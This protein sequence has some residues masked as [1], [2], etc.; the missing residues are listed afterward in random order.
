[1]TSTPDLSIVVCS[2]NRADRLGPTLRA[3]E[4]Q[5]IRDR[6]E[7]VIVDDCSNPPIDESEVSRSGAK[8]LRHPVN[9]GPAAARNTG[10]A[11]SRAPIVAFTDDDCR[12]AP[13]WASSLLS[14][15]SD[16]SVGAAGGPVA[17]SSQGRYLERYFTCK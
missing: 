1:M 7:I 5:T 2:Y 4:R 8:L 15:Y 12:P 16:G 10:A 17:G 3:L 14:G 9:K 13:E 11:A 6:L